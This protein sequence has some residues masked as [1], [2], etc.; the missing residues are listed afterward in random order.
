[1]SRSLF[2]RQW[3]AWAVLIGVAMYTILVG[4]EPSV[5]RAA[6]V[7]PSI[8]AVRLFWKRFGAFD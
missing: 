6:I 2:D 5:V 1:M 3:A 4:A 7:G 8:I